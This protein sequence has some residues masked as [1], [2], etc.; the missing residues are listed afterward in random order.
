MADWGDDVSAGCMAVLIGSL[1]RTMD[2]RIVHRTA[3]SLA[4]VDHLPR[5]RV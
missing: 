3:V 2:G 1:V 5:T 4:R